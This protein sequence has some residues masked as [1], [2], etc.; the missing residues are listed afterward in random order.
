MENSKATMIQRFESIA[1]G[2]CGLRKGGG[3]VIVGLSGGADSVCLL[4]LL[5]EAGFDC[6][7][8]HCNYHLRG[9]ESM[10][11][12]NWAVEIGQRFGLTTIVRDFQVVAGARRSVEMICRDRRYEL[13]EQIRQQCSGQAIAV[14]HHIEDNIETMIL[15]LTRGAGLRGVKGM[16]PRNG[17]IVRPLLHFRRSE[18]ENRLKSLHLDWV[19]D[20][21]N[22][23]LDYTRNRI[24]HDVL[25][26][27]AKI[28]PG[29]VSAAAASLDNLR[30]DFELYMDLIARQALRYGDINN[31]HLDLSA[32]VDNEKHPALLLWRMT[33]HLG[34]SRPVADEIIRSCREGSSGRLWTTALGRQ[35]LLDRGR[36]KLVDVDAV[37]THPD[38]DASALQ[39]HESSVD[40]MQRLHPGS[41]S[42]TAFFDSA[43][44]DG[45]HTI[46]VR[47][48]KPGDRIR[49]LGMNGRS[50]KVSDLLRDA[51]V[52]LDQKKHIRVMTVDGIPVWVIGIRHGADW[53]VTPGSSGVVR[54]E[55]CGGPVS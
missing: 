50:K 45:G 10:R 27:I 51:H 29:A 21:S 24:R 17:F 46:E 3:A 6:I 20:S 35:L 32:L 52:A 40:E 19:D 28:R 14:G 23:S 15:N 41:T 49:P 38:H 18:I 33:E 39:F 11:D 48:W 30:A 42:P 16:L 26:A 53:A 36:L 37:A 47:P 1:T 54:A 2:E 31:S 22:A 9:D 5:V 12:E 7:P 25:D 55:W 13:F 4:S 8:V 34:V 43:I 44:L